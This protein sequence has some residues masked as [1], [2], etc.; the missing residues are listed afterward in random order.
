M[1]LEK[2]VEYGWLRPEATSLDEIQGLLSIVDRGLHDSKV[3][4]ISIDLRF[5]A[6]NSA[7]TAATVALRAAGFRVSSQAG[8]HVKTIESLEFTHPE[9][10]TFVQKLKVMSN[11]R[12]R[13][14]YDV[15]GAVSDQDLQSM[16]KLA[17][18][19]QSRLRAWLRKEHPELLKG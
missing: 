15:A 12:N 6:F 5:M 8:H 16:M 17:A 11:K 2:W 19:L 7:L 13:S 14:N 4:E 9:G 3:E 10:R 18:D 1:S